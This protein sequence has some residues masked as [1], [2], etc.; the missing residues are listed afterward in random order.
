[1]K[2]FAFTSV[3][4]MATG[5]IASSNITNGR[6]RKLIQRNNDNGLD[7]GGLVG[8]ASRISHKL[9]LHDGAWDGAHQCLRSCSTGTCCHP[10][11]PDATSLAND[12]I[13]ITPSASITNA[14]ASST[15]PMDTLATMTRTANTSSD[16]TETGVFVNGT[17]TLDP[18][19]AP[20]MT[21][22]S[23]S[24]T[25]EPI[26]LVDAHPSAEEDDAT[27]V[28]HHDFVAPKDSSPADS[29]NDTAS[30]DVGI[31][32]NASYIEEIDGRVPLWTLPE[33]YHHCIDDNAYNCLGIGDIRKLTTDQ[34]CWQH[35]IE[36][37]TWMIDHLGWCV[38]DSCK[39]CGPSCRDESDLWAQE[40]CNW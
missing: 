40:V 18:K 38:M 11:P 8:A 4:V 29:I 31:A 2:F 13:A 26:K 9:A 6:H 5:A 17:G 37:E 24:S 3:A 27:L 23:A 20:S 7:V 19:D 34:F 36:V 33:C 14:T 22:N 21:I 32:L 1:M 30:L 16:A 28:A 25:S 15:Q 39:S 35:R 12:S 10:L